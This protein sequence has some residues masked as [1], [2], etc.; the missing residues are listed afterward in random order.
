MAGLK[1]GGRISRRGWS[2][3]S[4]NLRRCVGENETF[5]YFVTDETDEYEDTDNDDD[6]DDDQAVSCIKVIELLKSFVVECCRG[7]INIR[8]TVKPRSNFRLWRF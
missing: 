2:I 8:T 3:V 5:V 4:G 7:S 6:N 1:L